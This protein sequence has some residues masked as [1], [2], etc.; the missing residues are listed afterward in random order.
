KRIDA[1]VASNDGTAGGAISAL[2][3]ANLAGK[4]LVTGLDAQK[5]AVQRIV[6]GTQTM[7]IY[8]PIRPLAFGAVDAAMRLARKQHVDAPDRINNGKR[9]V[10]SILYEAIVVDRSNVDQTVIKDGYQRREEIYQ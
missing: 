10:P 3:A 8:T 7:T 9:D 2:E 4:V 5:D 1:I 6:R